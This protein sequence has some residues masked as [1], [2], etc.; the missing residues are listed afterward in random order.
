MNILHAVDTDGV[1][2]EL[3]DSFLKRYQDGLE[4]KMTGSSYFFEKVDL[5][6]YHFH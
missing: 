2:D 6:E 5:L 3:F 1:I 4:T